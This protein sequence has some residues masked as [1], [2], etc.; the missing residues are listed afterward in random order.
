M[1]DGN[2][3]LHPRR[4]GLACHVGVEANLPTIGIAKNEHRLSDARVKLIGDF[5]SVGS[6]HDLKDDDGVVLGCVC[7]DQLIF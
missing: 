2:G 4:F 5:T 6:T 3:L 1:V 7:F